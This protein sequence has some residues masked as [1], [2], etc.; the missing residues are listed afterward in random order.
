MYDVGVTMLADCAQAT[1]PVRTTPAAIKVDALVVWLLQERLVK[2]VSHWQS[3]TACRGLSHEQ[4]RSSAKLLMSVLFP[5]HLFVPLPLPLPLPSPSPSPPPSS[6]C[7][8]WRL[9]LFQQRLLC[10]WLI[11]SMCQSLLWAVL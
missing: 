1:H 6:W 9:L 5:Y 11:L 10:Q 7:V 8:L 2:L 3:P 4:S